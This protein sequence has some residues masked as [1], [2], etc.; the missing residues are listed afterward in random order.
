MLGRF[1]SRRSVVPEPA[2]APEPPVPLLP[3]E[4]PSLAV[5]EAP[6]EVAAPVNPLLSD[7]LL[8][9]K[10]RLHRRLIEEINLSVLEK[11]PDD[12]V[13]RHVHTLVSQYTLAERLALN[14]QE[15]EDFVAEILD[16]MTGL[17]PIEPLLKDPMVN[18]ILINGH[19]QVYVERAGVLEPT[20]VR[21][22][23]EPHLLRIVNKIVSAVGRRVDESQPLC[24]ARL[25]DGSRINIAVRPIAVDGPLVSIRKFSK[26]PYNLRKL[27]DIGA[28]RSQMAELLAAAVKARVTLIISGGTGSGKTTMLNALSAFISE[29]ERLITIEDAAELQLQQPH[30]GR[31]ETR[32][33]NI[34]SKGEIRQ[35]ELVKNALRMRPDRIILGECRGEEA[36]DMLQAMN[37]GHEGSMAT[38]HANTPRDALSR[39]EQMIGMAGLPMT[40]SSIRGQIAAAIRAI[41]QLQRLSD[42]K[43]VVTSIAEI[44]GLEGDIIQMQEIFKYQRTG[45]GEDGAVQGHF[46]A[47]GVR[48]R[49]LGELTAKGITV[50]ASHFDPTKPL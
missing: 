11:M 3:Q 46:Q 50:P 21:F 49:F 13:R 19:E 29:K 2:A 24:D 5:D 22:K 26:K 4:A 44:T 18:D 33:P 45:T 48:P 37:T 35:R 43:R 25:L 8:D 47:T 32:P 16:E 38:I 12:E 28:I 31:M 14:A 34:E 1:T 40:V 10:V 20:L 30:V 27:I 23:D 9:A 36:F 15:L 7:K 6:A 39:L 17:G 42:G 41:V